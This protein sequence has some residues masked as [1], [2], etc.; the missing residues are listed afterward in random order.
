MCYIII[1][2]VFIIY[3]KYL[4]SEDR[5]DKVLGLN[6]VNLG[7]ISGSLGVHRAP[8]G[9]IPEYNDSDIL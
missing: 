2:Y 5:D 3:I 1:Y 6:A 4:E 7:L 8:L 9:V